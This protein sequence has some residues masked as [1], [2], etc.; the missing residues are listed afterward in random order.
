MF[1]LLET[2][3]RSQR[4]FMD[5]R[6][7]LEMYVLVQE[8]QTNATRAHDIATI[9]RLV[10]SDETEDRALA[11]AVSADKSDVFSGIYL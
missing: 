2:A 11:G 4:R 8:T 7:R 6:A 5:R 1:N 3:K 10:I 9:C